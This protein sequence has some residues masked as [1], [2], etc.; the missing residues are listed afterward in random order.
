MARGV[1]GAEG[2]RLK[3]SN[4]SCW[5][6]GVTLKR[7]R[8]DDTKDSWRNTGLK[9]VKSYGSS[10]RNERDWLRRGARLCGIPGCW[11]EKAECTV[12]TQLSRQY[13]W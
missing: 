8:V 12:Q 11:R 3:M 5:C 7:A 10:L 4:V 13:I 2:E 6:V 1:L 9:G